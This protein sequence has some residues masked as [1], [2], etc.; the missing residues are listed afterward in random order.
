[1]GIEKMKLAILATLATFTTAFAG[2][3]YDIPM[4]DFSNEEGPHEARLGD[5]CLAGKKYWASLCV[6]APSRVTIHEQCTIFGTY[7]RR[8][9]RYS[10]PPRHHEHCTIFGMKKHPHFRTDVLN[11]LNKV[12]NLQQMMQQSNKNVVTENHLKM[13]LLKPLE[14]FRP[15]VDCQQHIVMKIIHCVQLTFRCS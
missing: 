8:P 6:K 9:T 1:M 12:M 4:M 14:N 3:K 13:I 15:F 5:V 7:H 11:I 10:T 2:I